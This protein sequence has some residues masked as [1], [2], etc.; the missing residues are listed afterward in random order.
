MEPTSSE[1]TQIAVDRPE[2]S[3]HD[4][5]E[6]GPAKP[7]APPNSTFPVP[8]IQIKGARQG[9]LMVVR[10]DASLTE[11]I[12]GIR[13]KFST[14]D[15]F[16]AGASLFLD[17]GWR[18]ADID[19]FVAIEDA[20]REHELQLAGVL[21]T[22]LTARESANKRGHKAMIGR[23]GLAGHHGRRLKQTRVE[24]Q[25]VAPELPAVNQKATAMAPF[26]DKMLTMAAPV[27]AQG[28]PDI[29]LESLLQQPAGPANTVASV[30]GES[31]SEEPES[32]A[33]LYIRRTLRSGVKAMYSGN[34]VVM[35]DVNP[36]AELE[37]D[38]DIIVV[39]NLR[40]KAHAGASGNPK[41]QIF[42]LSLQPIQIRIGEEIWSGGEPANRLKSGGP[43]RAILKDGKIAFVSAS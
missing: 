43:Q 41:S 32:E 40:G 2:P 15:S 11:V 10:E 37:A 21:S 31:E 28:R 22:S 23:L 14:E 7:T 1:V 4:S 18:E 17:L 3:V 33:T 26:F 16:L 6:M 25:S 8:A 19:F 36:G 39:G 38:G 13:V 9:L 24:S 42:A 5:L 34:I 29:T 30:E 12:D 20:F 27:P 35:G